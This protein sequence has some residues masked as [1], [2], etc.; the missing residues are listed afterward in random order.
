MI[1]KNSIL[2]KFRYNRIK[3]MLILSCN[4]NINKKFMIKKIKSNSKNKIFYFQVKVK[5]V[6]N[7]WLI[8]NI[9]KII[10]INI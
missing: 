4:Q 8:Y 5:I 1:I 6:K 9:Y 2:K 10:I 7:L 3:M